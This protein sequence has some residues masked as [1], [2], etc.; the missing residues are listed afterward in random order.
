MSLWPSVPV[1]T[2]ASHP[3]WPIVAGVGFAPGCADAAGGGP[4][5]LYVVLAVRPGPCGVAGGVASTRR[6]SAAGMVN[7]Q[8][9]SRFMGP[10]PP[11]GTDPTIETRT[12]S[13]SQPAV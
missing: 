8:V 2:P 9:N 6:V 10:P 4:F 3:I 13:P 11:G 12:L 5:R 1:H 7:R